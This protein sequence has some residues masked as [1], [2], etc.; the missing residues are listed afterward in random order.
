VTVN[1][2]TFEVEVEEIKAGTAADQTNGSVAPAKPANL[3]GNLTPN[4]APAS[5]PAPVATARAG[6]AGGG[7]SVKAPMPG[8]ILNVKIKEGD[9]V[10]SGQVLL[11][12]EAMKME[13]EIVAPKDGVV[14][15]VYVGPGQSVNTGD[16]LVDIE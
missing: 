13:N 10:K 7:G 5:S 1:G 8:N 12:L 15:R 3:V 4:P 6:A 14:K 11:I 16:P 2:E 9:N